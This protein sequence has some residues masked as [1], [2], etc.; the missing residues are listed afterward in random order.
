M[1]TSSGESC[2]MKWLAQNLSGP[3]GQ[4]SLNWVLGTGFGKFKQLDICY[5]RCQFS[6]LF[7]QNCFYPFPLPLSPHQIA[8]NQH[9]EI[10]I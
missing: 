7:F 9:Y 8:F 1:S 3:P 6:F 2:V 5:Q 10:L 4:Q